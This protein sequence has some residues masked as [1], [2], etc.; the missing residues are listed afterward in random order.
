M[1]ILKFDTT[2]EVIE[3]ANKTI[4]GLAAGICTRDVGR[5]IKVAS[6]IRAG[7]V[8]VNTYNSVS[9]ASGWLF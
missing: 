3:R 4:Y 5:A 7:T 2:E 6:E 9:L 8:W 1:S